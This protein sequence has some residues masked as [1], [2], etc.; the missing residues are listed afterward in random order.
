M[1]NI[2]LYYKY[3]PLEDPEL[4]ARWQHGLCTS[5]GLKGRIIIAPEGINGT[6]GGLSSALASY[7]EHMSRHPLFAD[8]DFKE[9]PG[10]ERNFPRLKVTVKKEIVRLGLDPQ[11]VKAAHAAPHLT[12][13]QVH[14]KIAAGDAAT[15]IFDV[16]N[17]YESAIGTFNGALTANIT[18]FSQLPSFI[19]TNLD[20]LKDKE[21]I[22]VCT[23]NVRC[24]RA[25][26]YLLSK[27]CAK[28][29]YQLLG[30]IHRYIEQFPNG[31]FRGKNFVFD[32]RMALAANDD[33]VGRCLQC[34]TAYDTYS[35]CA[36]TQCHRL[37]LLCP[38][39][40][41]LVSNTCGD[42]CASLTQER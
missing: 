29:V 28:A 22:M 16:R 4:I 38:D 9:S 33:I 15:L 6:L 36:N 26:A 12:P 42:T 7:K 37:L 1:E 21:V 3:I 41:P 27:G 10:G 39:C 35:H 32:G 34:S 19:D 24:E 25:S 23:G 5:L 20:C 14:D 30:G 2:I 17:S 40:K 11:Q 31:F 13:A 8:I 18:T